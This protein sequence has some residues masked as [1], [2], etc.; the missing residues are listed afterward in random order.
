MLF[1]NDV[2]AMRSHWSIDVAMVTGVQVESTYKCEESTEEPV[3]TETENSYQVSCFISQ[4]VKYMH[5]A[6]RKVYTIY[7]SV[8]IN[9]GLRARVVYIP[10]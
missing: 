2:I 1:I 7:T 8:E 6:L 3:T 9:E 4:D 5:T 10:I